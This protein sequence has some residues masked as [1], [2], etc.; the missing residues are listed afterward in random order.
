LPIVALTANAIKGDREL[1]LAAGMDA[2]VTKPIDPTRLIDTIQTL[3]QSTDDE[4]SPASV[5]L[6]RQVAEISELA[7]GVG[8]VQIAGDQLPDGR[9]TSEPID[10]PDLLERC[11]GKRELCGRVI[12]KFR[13]RCPEHRQRIARAMA[14]AD[15][16]D[17]ARAAHALKGAAANLSAGQLST[18]AA[19]IERVALDHCLPAPRTLENLWEALEQ[20]VAAMP[21]L[22]ATFGLDSPTKHAPVAAALPN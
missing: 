5:L 6:R 19:E 21:E 12:A 10:L 2:Y 17:L 20:L 7:L 8:P 14:A 18:A 1:C 22:L 3:L 16:D 13:D 4:T 11:Q 9:I 15:C